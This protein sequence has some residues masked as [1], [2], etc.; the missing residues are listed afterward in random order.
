MIRELPQ[1]KSIKS[2]L[3]LTAIVVSLGAGTITF[4]RAQQCANRT[5]FPLAPA[6]K[7][8]T[9]DA[10]GIIHITYSF[11]DSNIPANSQV[12]IGLAIGQWNNFSSSTKVRFDLAPSGSAGDLQFAP[13]DDTRLTFGC[14][15]H[16]SSTHRVNYSRAWSERAAD[17]SNA[18]AA[19]VAHEIG[20]F[21]G[22]DEAG[23]S[24]SPPTIMNNPHVDPD[25]TTCQNATMPTNTVQ[26]GDATAARGCIQAERPTPTPTP[27]PTPDLCTSHCSDLEAF[28]QTCFGDANICAYPDS[29]GC[30][31][32]QTNINGCCCAAETPIL[33]DILGNGFSLTDAANGVSFDLD[34][35]GIAVHLSWTAM[36]SDDAW[37]ALDR[38][39]NG[40]IDNGT[41]LFGNHTAQPQPP[42]GVARNGFLALAEFDNPANGGNGDGEIDEHD[43][44]FSSLR[45]WQDTNH[46]GISEPNELHTL[47]QLGVYAIDLNYK[48]SKQTDQYGNGFR[49]RAKVDDAKHTHVGRWAWDVVLL[50]R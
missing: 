21:Y 49:Y 19:F 18:G 9:P 1:L 12:A 22:L 36:N 4:L 11:A 2:L 37:L 47:P 45:L 14:I 27:A 39:G 48:Q 25:H 30:S 32:D 46:N 33:I 40:T 15:A 17:N 44:I 28:G 10:N 42:P 26:A 29:N 34:S 20:H 43:A 5:Q 3:L 35:N 8:K 16:D 23:E 50:S 41:E 31:P 38:N 7:N 6:L 24:P 13:S